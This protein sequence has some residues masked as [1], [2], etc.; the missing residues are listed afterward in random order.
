ME[1]EPLS[2]DLAPAGPCGAAASAPQGQPLSTFSLPSASSGWFL[3]RPLCPSCHF[4]GGGE[5]RRANLRRMAAH[6]YVQPQVAPPEALGLLLSGGGHNLFPLSSDLLP[7][8]L[9]AQTQEVTSCAPV[10]R[11]KTNNHPPFPATCCKPGTPTLLNLRGKD[12]TE[13]MLSSSRVLQRDCRATVRLRGAKTNAWSRDRTG[14][15]SGHR[16]CCFHH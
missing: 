5:R 12:F 1:T 14:A 16:H 10:S 2:T 4:P 11:G 3:S 9:P 6:H 8:P 7:H 13:R 15:N